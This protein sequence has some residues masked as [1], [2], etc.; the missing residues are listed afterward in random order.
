MKPQ[1]RRHPQIMAAEPHIAHIPLGKRAGDRAG[2][3][4]NSCRVSASTS[5]LRLGFGL[6]LCP[7]PFLRLAPGLGFQDAHAD[8]ALLLTERLVPGWRVIT[9]AP[10]TVL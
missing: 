5:T 7:R 2:L 4:I 6:C 10:A 3:C 8:F 9:D 1:F